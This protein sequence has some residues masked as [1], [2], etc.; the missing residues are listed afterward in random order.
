MLRCRKNIFLMHWKYDVFHL[1]SRNFANSFSAQ[2]KKI[3]KTSPKIHTN[4]Y[5][6]TGFHTF[7]L[8]FQNLACQNCFH[9][10][11][12]RGSNFFV[13]GRI[14]VKPDIYKKYLVWFVHFWT[15]PCSPGSLSSPNHVPKLMTFTEFPHSPAQLQRD[16]PFC[17]VCHW[18][19]MRLNPLSV[20]FM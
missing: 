10:W 3:N 14:M 12:L 11:T 8:V 7:P 4:A 16:P 13:R 9:R 5:I 15:F 19:I 18:Y 20:R 2:R 6:A 1:I 17:A